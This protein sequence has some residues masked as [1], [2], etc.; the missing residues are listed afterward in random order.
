MHFG[1][2]TENMSQERSYN[3]DKKP[4]AIARV[5]IHVYEGTSSCILNSRCHKTCTEYFFYLFMGFKSD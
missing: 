5:C 2:K 3:F 1:S 4:S